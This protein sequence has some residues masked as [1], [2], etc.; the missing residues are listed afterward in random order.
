M[1]HI[2]WHP[3]STELRRWGAV[4]LFGTAA[5]GCVLYFLLGQPALARSLW[6][7]GALSFSAGVTGTRAAL[8]FY[9]VWMSLVWVISQTLGTLALAAV[10]Y[11]VVTPIGLAARLCGRDR[12]KLRRPPPGTPTLWEKVPAVRQDRF[13]RPF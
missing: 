12:L 10:F 8:P 4:M 2:N 1:I 7:F 6:V 9:L 5:G 11:F 3:T 13:D